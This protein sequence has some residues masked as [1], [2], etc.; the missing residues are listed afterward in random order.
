MRNNER[1]NGGEIQPEHVWMYLE[2]VYVCLGPVH[3]CASLQMVGAVARVA[4]YL[5]TNSTFPAKAIKV[6]KLLN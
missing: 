6:S 4:S 1:E 5:T 2:C 3:V